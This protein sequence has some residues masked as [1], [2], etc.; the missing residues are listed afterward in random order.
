MVTLVSFDDER[1]KVLHEAAAL[2]HTPDDQGASRTV[3]CSQYQIPHPQD[4]HRTPPL[5]EPAP[6]PEELLPS[7]RAFRKDLA[8]Y[9]EV[10]PPQMIGHHKR[11]MAGAILTAA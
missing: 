9:M 10:R 11:S 3:S 4:G 6:P 8:Q 5:E 7:A 1:F 2:S